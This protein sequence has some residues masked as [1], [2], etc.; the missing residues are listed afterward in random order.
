MTIGEAPSLF[1]GSINYSACGEHLGDVLPDQLTTLWT[2]TIWLL[3]DGTFTRLERNAMGDSFQLLKVPRTHLPV[4]FQHGKNSPCDPGASFRMASG[5]ILRWH[6]VSKGKL[7]R[8]NPR[9][10]KPRL[11]RP[12]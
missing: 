10:G 6:L 12:E 1:E 5:G 7:I 8:W 11:N 3:E 4:V 9:C 2:G